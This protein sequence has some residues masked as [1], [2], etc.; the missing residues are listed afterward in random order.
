VTLDAKAMEW[1]AE[2]GI[3]T[4]TLKAAKIPVYGKWY[5]PE[6]PSA[7]PMVNLKSGEVLTFRP[8]MRA[9]EILFV[10]RADLRRAR[11]GPYAQLTEEE[12]LREGP[13]RRGEP[14][15][16]VAAQPRAALAEEP[17]VAERVEEVLPPGIHMPP[18]SIFPLILAF[19]ISI[20]LLGLVI[21]PH[22]NEP[23]GAPMRLLVTS[24]GLIYVLVGGIGWAVQ[25]SSEPGNGHGVVEQAGVE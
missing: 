18:P 6:L 14:A 22:W 2:Q 20:M 16:A 3:D 24:L 13:L 1:A 19:G 12:A 9:G 7:V 10:R 4:K 11:L 23:G 17:L 8:G 21:G 25:P 15:V 5:F